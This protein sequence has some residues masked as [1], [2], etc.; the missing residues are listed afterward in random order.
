M[1]QC[2][3]RLER[4]YNSSAARQLTSEIEANSC[5]A[6]KGG[7][8]SCK[9]RMC[10]SG[11]RYEEVMGYYNGPKQ[12]IFICAEKAP[13]Q[14]E[15][16][17]SLVHQLSVA[18]DHC[19]MGMRVP[20]VGVQAPWALS[21]AATACAEVRGYLRDSL[22]GVASGGLGGG[23]GGFGG[24]FGGGGGGGFDGGGGNGGFMTDGNLSD[25]YSSSRPQSNTFGGDGLL[26][27]GQ[28]TSDFGAGDGSL[29]SSGPGGLPRGPSTASDPDRQR[30]AV[31]SAAYY[32]LSNYGACHQ[33]RR[34][35]RGVLDAVFN[36]CLDDQAPTIKPPNPTGA[37]YPPLPP[38]VA[39]AEK[40]P[41]Q[42]AMPPPG[43]V[44]ERSIER[45][46][47]EQVTAKVGEV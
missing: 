41:A 29:N 19:R 24:G 39:E 44:G 35:P 23:S 40:L 2:E 45:N 10:P 21:C 37:P 11:E 5:T 27:R 26:Q 13:T 25:D 7:R 46:E 30:E 20:F 15:V 36:A 4:A 18:Y 43:G 33:E 6:L 34:E 28:S 16:D 22:R 31:Y 14:E 38:E 9:C 8:A 1:S 32:S 47:N 17:T 3:Q 42:R 12:K